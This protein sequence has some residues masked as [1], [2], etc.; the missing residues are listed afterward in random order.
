MDVI[1]EYDT[2]IEVKVSTSSM[3]IDKKDVYLLTS[4]VTFDKSV[5][6]FYIRDSYGVKKYLHR[7]LMGNPAGFQIDHIN[8]NKTDNRRSNLRVVSEET[9][10]RNISGRDGSSIYR[11]VYWSN[12]KNK[13]ET[14]IV[15]NKKK[16]LCGSFHNQVDAAIA[17]DRKID[18]I[19]KEPTGKNFPLPISGTTAYLGGTFDCL[20]PGHTELF[21]NT[22]K[23]AERLIVSLNTDDFVERF[24]HTKTIMT[25]DER[26]KMVQANK[27]VDGVVVNTG[28]EDSKPS[29]LVVK[30]QYIIH[31]D[32]WVGDSLMSQLGIDKNFL[33]INEIYMVYM[34]YTKTISTTELKRRIA[35]G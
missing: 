6:Y 16:Y 5:G 13:W 32:D 30:P 15:V 35:E 29:I 4:N 23:V 1:K 18:E 20:H 22:K 8:Q 19:Y 21:K 11:G 24:K 12:Q 17:V 27:Y 26:I 3:L 9:N 7:V 2:F 33:S 31:G 25:L 10:K 28:G 14:N 34:P